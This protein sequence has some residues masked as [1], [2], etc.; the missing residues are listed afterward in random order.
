MVIR[1]IEPTRIRVILTNCPESFALFSNGKIYY[2][3]DLK[4][5]RN[6]LQLNINDPGTYTTKND[7]KEIEYLPR[8]KFT[9]YILSLPAPEKNIE[10]KP[11]FYVYKKDIGGTPARIDVS[12]GEVQYSDFFLS[13]PKPIQDFIILHEIGH[14]YYK[15]ETLADS[16]ALYHYMQNYGNP[17]Q[18]FYALAKVFKHPEYQSERIYNLFDNIK[19]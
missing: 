11:L 2:Q 7:I 15:T 18:A 8:K 16:Y 1:I 13:L 6:E 14:N 3:R 12:T 4:G 19:H 5:D 9:C 10:K 17:S